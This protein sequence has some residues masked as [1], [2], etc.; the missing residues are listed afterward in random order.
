MSTPMS[1]EQYRDLAAQ[2]GRSQQRGL[3]LRQRNAGP[4][5]AD[6]IGILGQIGRRVAN[7]QGM[8]PDQLR[9]FLICVRIW[10]AKPSQIFA[11]Q[12]RKVGRDALS[13]IAH[14]RQC[15]VVCF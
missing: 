10:Q 1:V 15:S 2:H 11:G 14:A 4:V 12:R 13:L 7:G 3:G 5:L 6:S 8:H 9:R